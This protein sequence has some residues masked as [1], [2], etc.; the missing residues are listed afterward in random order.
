LTAPSFGIA[1]SRSWMRA[2]A[3]HS[4]GSSSTSETLTSPRLSCCLK[5]ARRTRTLLATRS[6]SRRWAEVREGAVGEDVATATKPDADHA[7]R[8]VA[9]RAAAHPDT[10]RRW[11]R[12]LGCTR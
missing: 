7:D 3:S 11:A 10:Q 4:G 2:E 5:A 1:I 6:A 12:P 8:L 9:G